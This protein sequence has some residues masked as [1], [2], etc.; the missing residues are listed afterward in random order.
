MMS[1]SQSS[2][3]APLTH[4]KERWL[5][6]VGTEDEATDETVL[7]GGTEIRYLRSD[8]VQW[9]NDNVPYRGWTWCIVFATHEGM[10]RGQGIVQVSIRDRK[11]AAKFKLI[12]GMCGLDKP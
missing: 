3:K 4:N 6:P 5:I 2:I 8:I 7:A 10:K 1:V 11:A 12:Y 9:L